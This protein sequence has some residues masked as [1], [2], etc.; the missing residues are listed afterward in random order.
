M[1]KPDPKA[2]A[3]KRAGDRPMT[4]QREPRAVQAKVLTVDEARR[5]ATNIARALLGRRGAP[6]QNAI[7]AP[8][9]RPP[10]GREFAASQ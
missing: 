2:K 8:C 10:N 6:I 4:D 5:I 1:A 9:V 7:K 3:R